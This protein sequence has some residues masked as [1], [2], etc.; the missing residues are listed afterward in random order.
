MYFAYIDLASFL[1]LAFTKAL[2]S[3]KRVI[4]FIFTEVLFGLTLF[5]FAMPFK[6][7]FFTKGGFIW[8]MLLQNSKISVLC[9][10]FKKIKS[11]WHVLQFGFSLNFTLV[12]IF[13][14][15]FR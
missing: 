11:P 6:S 14:S 15:A 13:L 5:L 10:L 9:L 2:P 3:E 12:V 1:S 4:L 8:Y 7:N